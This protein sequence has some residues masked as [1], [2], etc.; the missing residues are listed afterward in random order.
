MIARPV[1]RRESLS[2][3]NGFVLLSPGIV[4]SRDDFRLTEGTLT[5]TLSQREREKPSKRSSLHPSIL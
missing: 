1:L 3:R 2:D 5:P 4:E